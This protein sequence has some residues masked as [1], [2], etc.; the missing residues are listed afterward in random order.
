MSINNENNLIIEQIP[1]VNERYFTLLEIREFILKYLNITKRIFNSIDEVFEV[2]N[3]PE[4]YN[5][6]TSFGLTH[7]HNTF[8]DEYTILW[9]FHRI[10]I[11]NFINSNDYDIGY[12]T[13]EL[14]QDNYLKISIGDLF[15]EI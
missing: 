1:F 8:F 10:V 5:M 4:N 3:I 9:P 6:D 7:H 2:L 11:H 15:I 14:N 12:F 13:I